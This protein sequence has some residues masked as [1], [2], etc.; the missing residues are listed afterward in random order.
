MALPNTSTSRKSRFLGQVST[1]TPRGASLCGHRVWPNLWASELKMR[2]SPGIMSILLR[3]KTVILKCPL[4][5][6][7]DD[8]FRTPAVDTIDVR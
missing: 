8:P 6:R 4:G 3:K 2:R 5:E 7:K 1:S